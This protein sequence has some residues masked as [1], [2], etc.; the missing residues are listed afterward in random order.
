[1]VVVVVVEEGGGWRERRGLCERCFL[2]RVE[3]V[4]SCVAGLS[5]RCV[6]M[7]QKGIVWGVV[8]AL[9]S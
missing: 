2:D 4:L 1:M 5:V 3:I 8:K 6:T 7:I 9:V